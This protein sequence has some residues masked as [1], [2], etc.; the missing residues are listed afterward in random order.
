M[1][2]G[3]THQ[4]LIE[5]VNQQLRRGSVVLAVLSQLKEEKYGYSLR[6]CLE[7]KGMKIDEGTLY[8]LLRR[9]ESQGLLKS[10]WKIEE[11]RPR[12]YYQ[13]NDRGAGV[14][15]ELKQE[16]ENLAAVIGGLLK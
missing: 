16:W 10:D 9:L 5:S 14:L 7:E 6:T 11:G 8:P 2:Q 4:Q 3:D 13:L 12:R 1:A 15:E